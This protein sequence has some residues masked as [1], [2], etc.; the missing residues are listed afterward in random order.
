M[1]KHPE[2]TAEH[3]E[4]MKRKTLAKGSG[5]A[6]KLEEALA[7]QDVRLEDIPLLG[8]PDPE[9]D[10]IMRLRHYLAELNAALDRIRS[11]SVGQCRVGKEP[12]PL[13]QLLEMPWADTCQTHSR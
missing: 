13:A 1:F 3:L 5:V 11:G 6:K 8:H 4:A 10:K 12:I 9:W 7:G 2:L